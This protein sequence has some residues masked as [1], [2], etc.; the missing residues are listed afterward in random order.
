MRCLSATSRK[1][2]AKDA[3]GGLL[4]SI[5]DRGILVLKDFT[6][7]LSMNRDQ[8]A[9][10][11]AA[12]REVYDGRWNRSV[13]TD[14]GRTLSWEGRI[15]LI[16]ATTTAYD[17]HHSVIAAMGDRFTLIRMD[18]TTGRISAGKQALRNVGDEPSMREELAEVVGGL[19]SG[20]DTDGAV[21]SDDTM[22]V[23][24][25]AA[26]LVTLA[27][28]GVERDQRGDIIDAHAPEMPTRFA[29]MLAQ[30]V[31]GGLALG[32]DEPHMINLALRVAADSMP[33]LRLLVLRDVAENTY[34]RTTDVAKRVQRP[35]QSVDRVLQEL[36]ILGVLSVETVDD[37]KGWRYQLAE[38]IDIKCLDRRHESVTRKVSNPTQEHKGG[39]HTSTDFSGDEPSNPLFD[40]W[41]AQAVAHAPDC[42]DCQHA[43]VFPSSPCRVHSKAS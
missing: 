35:R 15:V 13:G 38:H 20:M 6:S 7:I 9:A 28:T 12:L 11:L 18:S 32:I 8:R 5:G 2:T 29:K 42:A 16:G 27:R 19:I 37:G 17:S 33:P 3:T 31:R 39:L 14:G 34:A 25:T 4:R 43:Y 1:E 30:I 10:V 22:D 36:H 40:A 21:L 24:L 23:L 41:Q 26:D